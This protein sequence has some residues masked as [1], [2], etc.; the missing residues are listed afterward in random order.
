MPRLR[1]AALSRWMTR[2]N[3]LFKHQLANSAG[4]SY[5]V[6][7]EAAENPD[8]EVAQDLLDRLARALDCPVEELGR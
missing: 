8:R 2:R 1:P 6:L 5:E 3:I 4:I 7:R